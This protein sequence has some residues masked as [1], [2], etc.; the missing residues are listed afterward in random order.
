MISRFHVFIFYAIIISLNAYGSE[1]NI[2]NSVAANIQDFPL[3]KRIQSD[4]IQNNKLCVT[5]HL[6]TSDRVTQKAFFAHLFSQE[7]KQNFFQR[8]R[9]RNPSIQD[10][11]LEILFL[12]NQSEALKKAVHPDNFAMIESHVIQGLTFSF[13]NKNI[14]R[15]SMEIID[16]HE[17]FS[18][19]ITLNDHEFKPE[20]PVVTFNAQQ[21]TITQTFA[22]YN[23]NDLR[24]RL[25]A[26]SWLYMQKGRKES[27]TDSLSE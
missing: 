22:I 23:P 19:K 12:N 6:D 4:I 10:E 7:K 9:Q 1:S 21:K 2:L 25:H 20:P 17:Q 24:E 16:T 13:I 8:F 5:L 15:I 18:H 11:E 3:I 14:V 27:D 26:A